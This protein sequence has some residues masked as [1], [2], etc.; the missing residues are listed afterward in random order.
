MIQQ[1]L[2]KNL[3]FSIVILFLLSIIYGCL[4]EDPNDCSDSFLDDN[5]TTQSTILKGSISQDLIS[6]NLFKG[7]EGE[8]GPDG[9]TGPPEE[10]EP[11]EA[12]NSPYDE[13][14]GPDGETG[15][16]EDG[17][18]GDVENSPTGEVGGVDGETGPPAGTDILELP[19]ECYKWLLSL[20][21]RSRYV[22]PD[23][24]NNFVFDPCP[25]GN[26]TLALLN[27]GKVT[28]KIFLRMNSNETIDMGVISPGED[29]FFVCSKSNGYIHA[30]IDEDQDLI[31]DNF[32]DENGDG[33]CD[34]RGRPF[35]HGYG[36]IDENNDGKNDNFVDSD[37]DGAND[38]Y[39][40]VDYGFHFG[41]IDKDNNGINDL[42]CDADGDGRCDYNT[43]IVY[44]HG[45]GFEDLDGDGIN[46]RFCD[47]DGN[48]IN[49]VTGQ[50]ARYGYRFGFADNNRDGNNDVFSDKDGNG[51]CDEDK[52]AA[53]IPFAHGFG[54]R[55]EDGDGINDRFCDA[56]GNGVNDI[57]NRSYNYGRSPRVFYDINEDGIT[58]FFVD[59]NEDGIND[60]FTDADGNG[61]NDID[62]NESFR[63][64]FGWLDA[65]GNGINDNFT[66]ADG[67]LKNDLTG[68]LYEIEK[69]GDSSNSGR[70][71]NL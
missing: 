39:P 70:G 69:D 9:T 42:F 53:G 51:I 24:I 11:G 66:D 56:D 55:D 19:I 67:D 30:F 31:N 52:F 22:I 6:R 41:F 58:D 65:D 13:P 10:V 32:R 17:A 46:D 20:Q 38:L 60:D 57:N 25:V 36:W 12:T 50:P 49:D 5:N 47:A 61:I 43:N 23:A 63:H 27:Y 37:G 4:G 8:P 59:K 16:P 33:I 44:A 18:T 71:G 54:W 68:V 26:H 35:A 3:L 2:Y 62:N 40:N 7:P 1:K 21:G 34:L 28:G 15:P 48:G 29:G 64:G 45:Y 14:G